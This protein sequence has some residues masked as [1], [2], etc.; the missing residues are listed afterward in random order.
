MK[1]KEID[2]LSYAFQETSQKVLISRIT[3]RLSHT[4]CKSLPYDRLLKIYKRTQ[5]KHRINH[6]INHELL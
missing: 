5:Y 2:N 6:I 4:N 3:T 1:G